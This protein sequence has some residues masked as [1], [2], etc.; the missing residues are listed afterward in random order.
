MTWV[1][2][3]AVGLFALVW[4]ASKEQIALM[5]EQARPDGS[6]IVTIRYKNFFGMTR[7]VER[8]EQ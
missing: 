8:V 1:A 5:S 4:S 7:K 6:K 3:I 2:V